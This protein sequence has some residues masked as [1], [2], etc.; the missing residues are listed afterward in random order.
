MKLFELN[1]SDFNI[2][3][4]NFLE[5]KQEQDSQID[6]A[7]IQIEQ[8]VKQNRF[9]ALKEYSRKFDNYDLT[10]ENFM[11][12][13]GE[14]D[15][16]A[17]KID[18]AL[19][20][21]LSTA[22]ERV[23][24]FHIKQKQESFK[25]RDKF[26]NFMGQEIIPL[27]SAAIYVPGGGA[28]YPSTVYMSAIPAI[29][30]GVK[31]IIILSPPRTF[32]ESPE[33]AKIIQLLDIKEVYRIGGAHAIFAAVYGVDKLKPVDK[34]VGP[35]NIFVAKAKQISFGKVAID[36]IA[37][38]S[39]ILVVADTDKE[40]DIPLIASDLL[41]QAEHG[42]AGWTRSI[43]IGINKNF[44]L[45][46]KEETYK[47][48]ESL[49]LK[50]NAIKSLDNQGIIIACKDI[51]SCMEISN[52]FA[53]EHLEIFSDKPYKLLKFV[54]NAGSVFLGKNTPEAVGD[55]LGGPNHVLPTSRTAR[56]FSPLGVYD[57]QKR[58]S[59]IEFNRKSL[60]RYVNDIATIARSEKL[61]AHAR[62]AEKRFE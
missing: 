32:V 10:P 25:M 15:T 4:I 29:I 21:S 47:Q 54:K 61:E 17:N 56:F 18:P 58:F 40:E 38:P 52:K 45:K 9:E 60:K 59:W 2:D 20:K 62:S 42:P 26:G 33:V 49:P 28:L 55:Y 36:M 34:I 39:E 19:S 51:F 22:I 13:K 57:F 37:G 5:E 11:V 44:L 48:A 50:E 27:E 53:P 30:A 1:D 14:I 7:V 31:R 8:N 12:S 23:K 46:I 6:E 41:S 16:L 43:L 24:A 35:G 3:L